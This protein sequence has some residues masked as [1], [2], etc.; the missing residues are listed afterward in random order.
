MDDTNDSAAG[1]DPLRR[2][3]DLFVYAPIG[4]VAVA[5]AELPQ[6]IASGRSKVDNQLTVAKFIGK[7]AVTQAKLEVGRRLD[8]AERARQAASE[9]SASPAAPTDSTDSTGSAD[10]SATAGV[11]ASGIDDLSTASLPEAIIELV[12]DSPLLAVADGSDPAVLPID[13]YDSLAA[14]QVVGRLGTLTDAELDAIKAYETAHRA[15]R[16]ILGKINQLRVR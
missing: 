14:S 11:A 13:G 16:T 1:N 4:L 6:L 15:R 9:P 2:I 7:M 8:D 5:T 3:L 10:P 12:A